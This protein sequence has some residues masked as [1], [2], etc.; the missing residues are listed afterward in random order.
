M[1]P[2]LSRFRNR[3]L[4]GGG[5]SVVLRK[6]QCGPK[7]CSQRKDENCPGQACL[8][9]AKPN[10][11]EAAL[12]PEAPWTQP[13][14]ALSFLR[15]LGVSPGLWAGDRNW[16]PHLD[17]EPGQGR[18]QVY[19]TNPGKPSPSPAMM[20][21]RLLAAPLPEGPRPGFQEYPQCQFGY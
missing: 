20:P 9:W 19:W 10:T 2:L 6:V 18:G 15:L 16:W 14:H 11:L 8:P 4:G 21:S 3:V 5:V 17:T 13:Q 12:A 7:F 1:G